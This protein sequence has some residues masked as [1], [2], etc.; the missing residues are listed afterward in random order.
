MLGAVKY[1]LLALLLYGLGGLYGMVVCLASYFGLAALAR[2]S[3]KKHGISESDASRMG[4]S[5]VLL[6][7]LGSLFLSTGSASSNL[8]LVQSLAVVVPMVA[9]YLV[10]LSDDIGIELSPSRRLL[11]L[12]LIL[13]A[14]LW[15]LGE[16]LWDRLG[17]V[18]QL[19][20]SVLLLVASGFFINAVNTADGAN[21]LV[22]GTVLIFLLVALEKAAL[23]STL[24]MVVTSCLVGVGL[25]FILNI[26]LGRFF[27]GDGGSYLLGMLVVLV[28]WQQIAAF[29]LQS[30]LLLVAV[31][32][33]PL[34]DLL[35]SAARRLLAG[36]SPMAADNGHLHNLVYR[37]VSKT[38]PANSAN[39]VTGV[40][41]A[42]VFAG[43]VYLF[44]DGSA[45][46]IALLFCG[47]I[48]L[49]SALWVLLARPKK[50]AP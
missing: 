11:L 9:I 23:N 39:S 32:T 22:S 20:Y 2:D 10:G 15:V 29:S 28:L 33:Y 18:Q 43:P 47:Q 21:G 8:E 34:Y 40:G 45:G 26:C 48:A 7:L 42:L 4:G 36:R 17:L 24:L 30:L 1:G 19:L 27:L 50:N 14:S 3:A 13:S 38:I 6:Y 31:L 44:R 49:Y 16:T 5:V 37:R 46:D 25:F 35:F 12:L 41:I